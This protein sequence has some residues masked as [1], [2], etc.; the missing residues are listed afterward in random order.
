MST[1]CGHIGLALIARK[2]AKLAFSI[3]FSRFRSVGLVCKTNKN[4]MKTEKSEF[5]CASSVCADA[6]VLI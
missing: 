5:I 6:D 2:H 1:H 3:Y 4:R